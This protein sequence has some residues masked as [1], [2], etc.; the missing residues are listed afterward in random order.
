MILLSIKRKDYEV[1][2]CNASKL[3]IDD[4]MAGAGAAMMT[5]SRQLRDQQI[6]SIFLM[7]VTIVVNC[8]GDGDGEDFDFQRI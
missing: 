5:L 6:D 3:M 2:G 7:M 4:S 8:D 1:S